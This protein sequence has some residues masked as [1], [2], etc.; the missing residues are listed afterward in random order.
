MKATTQ[1]RPSS[2]VRPSVEFQPQNLGVAL[3][4]LGSNSAEVPEKSAGIPVTESEGT[5]F[6]TKIE[7]ER[8]K[9][10]SQN[11]DE[12]H[13]GTPNLQKVLVGFHIIQD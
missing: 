7:S 11:F 13:G 12:F 2:F 5:I 6:S 9:M 8:E 10:L 4:E 1:I 3:D